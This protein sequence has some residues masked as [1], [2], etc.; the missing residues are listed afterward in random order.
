MTAEST[1]AF[2]TNYILNLKERTRTEIGGTKW[3]IDWVVYNLG[4][5]LYGKPVR[6]PF[7]RLEENSGVRTKPEAEFG[8][9]VSFLSSDKK[10]LTIFVLKDEALT[11]KTWTRNGFYEDLTKAINPDLRDSGLASVESVEVVLAY[12]RDEQSNGVTLFERFVECAPPLLA[13]RARLTILRWNLSD[14][15]DLTLEHLLTPAL[16]PQEFFGQLNYLCA[17]FADFEHGTDAWERQLVPA[18]NRFLSDVLV[19]ALG[20]RGTALVPVALIILRQHGSSNSTLETGWLD[21]IEW[22]SI[23]MWRRFT[24]TEDT[25][26]QAQIHLFW[27]QFYVQELRRFYSAHIDAIATQNAID[28]LSGSTMVGVV[29]SS[30][31]AYWHLGRIGLLSLA[32]SEMMP[33][34]TAD[35]CRRRDAV[36]HEISNWIIRLFNANEA[37]FRPL[38]DINHIEIVLT[39]FAFSNAGRLLEFGHLV[40]RLIQNLYL[41]RIKRTGIPFLD[42]NNSLDNVFEQVASNNDDELVT[43]GSSFFVVMLMEVCCLLPDDMRDEL[44]PQIH[45]RLV[46][47]AMDTG[48]QPEISALN[49]MS[50]IP[51]TDWPQKI[52]CGQV[53]DG[54]CVSRG[55]LSDS[56]GAKG[57]E[58]FEELRRFAVLMRGASDFPDGFSV[59]LAALI[60]AS[61]RHSSPLPPELW[62]GSAFPTE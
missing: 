12:N 13:G 46:F 61:I 49:L 7:L 44:L 14:L 41:R 35:D 42:G 21:L 22:A 27:Q 15:V 8:V 36:I 62:R 16:L 55:P 51:P 58:L 17:Q 20:R 9:D 6:L 47:G 18:W 34:A 1:K 39:L 33:D 2:L 3:G 38:L 26:T 19:E 50:W 29:A 59:P 10:T 48:N 37:M 24:E 4:Q 28:A 31:V 30:S 23:A 53:R 43:T 45:R 11:N 54:H 32:L 40:P 60:L 52:F 25:A 56:L 5:A 57:P